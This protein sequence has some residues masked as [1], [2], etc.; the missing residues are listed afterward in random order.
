MREYGD[1]IQLELK[2]Y[3]RLLPG[4][5][6]EIRDEIKNQYGISMGKYNISSYLSRYKKAGKIGYNTTNR[7]W[8]KKNDQD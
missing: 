5:T 3:I 8:E 4:T 6:G 1:K 2:D 7:K